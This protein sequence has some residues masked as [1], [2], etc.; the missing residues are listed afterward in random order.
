MATHTNITSIQTA[1]TAR[2]V[3]GGF[4]L[5]PMTKLQVTAPAGTNIIGRPRFPL[6]TS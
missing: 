3:V 4:V 1:F 6:T 2:P 5:A